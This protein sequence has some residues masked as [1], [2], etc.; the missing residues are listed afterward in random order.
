MADAGQLDLSAVI[1]CRNNADTIER[2]LASV[3]PLAAEI[4]AVDSGSTDGTLELLEQ[5]GAAITRADWRGYVATKQMALELA[6]RRWA[7]CLDS[8]ESLEPDLAAS[9]RAALPEANDAPGDAPAFALNRKVWY[10]GR[11]L[12]HAWQPEWRTRLV[13]RDLVP[14]TIRW[15][16]DDPHD[17]LLVHPSAGPVRRLAGDLRH[18]TI[19]TID[20]FLAQQVRLGAVAADS[21]AARGRTGSILRLAT[22]PAGAFCK[23][24][25]L[26]GAWRDGWRGWLAAT[27]S[28]VAAAAKHAALVERT[29][30]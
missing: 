21:F 16:G 17:A 6:T 5:Y 18:D 15:G 24:L 13:R 9:I 10:A 23:Q 11:F 3:R 19:G 1:V 7:L 22:S 26:K 8:D 25:I 4:I 28:G 20:R 27:A 2:T 30:R 12:D 14:E 29:R